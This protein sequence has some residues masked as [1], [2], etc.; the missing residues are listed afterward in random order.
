MILNP[1]F[2]IESLNTRI[3]SLL[4]SITWEHIA[5][6]VILLLVIL[7]RFYGLGDRVMSHDETQHTYFSWLFFKGHG[8]QHT[9]LTHGPLQFHLIALSYSLFGDTDLASRIPHALASIASVLFLW[10]YRRYLGRIGTL[11]AAF[12]MLISP[13]MLFYGRYARNESL[14]VLFGLITVWAVLR[15]LESGQNRYL[16]VLTAATALHFTAKETVFIYTAQLILFL[17]IVLVSRVTE[18]DWRRQAYFR[19][20]LLAVIAGILLLCVGFTMLLMNT[21]SAD[22]GASSIPS[23]L[24]LFPVILSLLC[25]GLAIFFV[26]RGLGITEIRRERTFNLI[27]LLGLIVLPQ[28]APFPVKLFGWNPLDYTT[29]GMLHTAIFL[30]PLVL[31]TVLIG[32]WWNWRL[33]LVCMALFYS[34]FIVFYTSVFTNGAGFFTGLVGSLG[35]WLEQQGVQRGSQPWYYYL[36]IQIPIYEFLPLLGAL[37]AGAIVVVRK[38]SHRGEAASSG[39][40]VQFNEEDL[41]VGSAEEGEPELV[42]RSQIIEEQNTAQ[43]GEIEGEPTSIEAPTDLPPET[44]PQQAP[45]LSLL[46]FWA[47]TSIAAY[48]LAGEKMPWLTVH[49]TLPLILLAGWG[50]GQLIEKIDW[51]LFLKQKGLLVLLLLPLFTH[52]LRSAL[53]LVMQFINGSLVLPPDWLG[54]F[55]YTSFALLTGGLLLYF[56]RG[57]SPGQF[58]RLVV[59]G[60]FVVMGFL[61][62]RTSYQAAFIRYDEATE[63]LVYAHSAPANKFL[64]DQIA[65]LSQRVN[66]DLS[67]GIAYDNSDGQ[68]DPASAWPLTWYLRNFTNTHSY[69][70]EVTRDLLQYPVIFASDKNWD[71]VEPLVKDTYDSFEYI[72]MWWPMQDYFNLTWERIRNA[73]TDPAMRAALWDI[74]LNRDYTAYARLTKQDLSL[75]NWEPS[76]RMR[77]YIRKDM[78]SQVW[79]LG[80]PAV[81]VPQPVDPYAGGMIDLQAS[82]I[83]GE[84]GTDPGQFQSPR[85]LAYA[86]DGSLYVADTLNHRIQHLGPNGAVLNAWG[87]YSGSDVSLAGNAP[88][89]TFNEPWDV[90]VGPDGTVYVADTWNNRIQK[91]TPDGQYLTSW[92]FFGQAETPDAFWGPRGVAVDA[93]GRVFVS[94]TGNKRVSVFD[95]D[96]NPLSIIKL[97]LNEPVG[98]AIGPDGRLYIADTW[99]Q[100]VVVAK[101]AADNIF[102]L[103]TSWPIDGWYSQSLDNKPYISVSSDGRVFVTDPEGY[104]VI[105]FSTNGDFVRTWGSFGSSADAFS[106]PSGISAG[107]NGQIWVTDNGANRIMLFQ[108]P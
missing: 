24:V 33:F 22:S 30:V 27:M 97:D 18:R 7:S 15:Y 14:V 65:E 39:E 45:V 2:T 44:Y 56:L 6:G 79:G 9:P 76:R 89:G 57:W 50:I 95:S 80:S 64:T 52:S 102:A 83:F 8:Y 73:L 3:K 32:V 42:A 11:V 17:A 69:G 31:L 91:F 72:R 20:F 43:P 90:A 5:F 103:D 25:F 85:G 23:F 28:L 62:V 48:T 71:K 47:V 13:Y 1:P 35:Y 88:V 98:I 99:N 4:A 29:Q 87:S 34:I 74:W 70:P 81:T 78:S 37:L 59:L 67:L 60:L 94:D 106:L 92:G 63:F 96:G 104:R 100:R 21:A 16:L 12:L 36:L 75:P 55:A 61:T 93:Q 46:G 86:P 40:V 68:G 53:M 38:I 77:V 107:E 19:P 41:V 51:R 108:A 49:I 84:L 54:L 82:T 66:N 101:E 58:G 105:E 10:N 26:V